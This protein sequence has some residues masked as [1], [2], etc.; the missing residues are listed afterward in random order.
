MVP[1]PMTLPEELV[2]QMGEDFVFVSK[3]VAWAG[4][5][6]IP[7]VPEHCVKATFWWGR[8]LWVFTLRLQERPVKMSGSA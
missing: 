6:N 7:V 2:H 3:I 4:F 1:C 5:L 8:E